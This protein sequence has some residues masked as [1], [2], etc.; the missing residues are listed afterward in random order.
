MVGENRKGEVKNSIG[1]VEAKELICMTH[2]HELKR[3]NVGG[4]E[5]A[6]QR[7]IKGGKCDNCNSIINKIYIFKNLTYL[8]HTLH[9]FHL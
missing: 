5:C 9:Q 7:G 3:G 1:N 4:R 6:R 8:T 2:G